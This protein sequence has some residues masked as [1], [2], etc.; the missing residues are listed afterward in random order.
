MAEGK[1]AQVV[2]FEW[3][4]GDVILDLYE[5]RTV[6]E[7]FGDNAREKDYHEGGFG[8]V[9]KVWHRTWRREMAVK[10]PRAGVFATQKQK[11]TFTRECETWINL[12]LHAHIAACHYVRDLCG[13]PRVFSEYAVAGTLED[14][15]RS[16]R[17]YEGD[18][19]TALARIL[20]AAI[21]FA[22]GLHY[23]HE[24]GVIHQDVKPL[25]ALMWDDGTLKVTDFGLTGARQKAGIT[26]QSGD[27][28]DGIRSIMVS[29]GGMT[30]SH[31]SPE[32]AAGRPLDRR[33][34]VWSWAVSV[35]EMFQGE[36]TW[37]SGS[38]AAEAL[39]A[40][41]EESASANQQSKIPAMPNG[42]AELLRQCFQQ[43]PA[44]R[45]HTMRDCTTV[46][47]EVYQAETGKSYPRAEPKDI[48]DTADALNNRAL[49]MLDLGKPDEAERLFDCALEVDKHHVA[50]TCNRSLMR[51]RAGKSTYMDALAS[52]EEIKKEHPNEANLEC[53]LGWVRME[54]A[55]FAK[56]LC[57]FDKA[58]ELGDD[59]EARLGL[60]QARPLAQIG[61]GQCLRTFEEHTDR[62]NCVAFSP[63]GLFVLSGSNDDTL[64]LWDVSTGECLRTFSCIDFLT[65]VAYSPD[66]RLVISGSRLHMLRLWDVTTGKCLRTFEG[67]TADV[68]SVA[69]S[70]DGRFVLSGSYDNTLRWW[71][72][73]TGQCIRIFEGHTA[74]V[75]SVAYSPDGRFVLSG[76]SDATLRLWDVSSVMARRYV[77]PWFYSMV[78]T[79]KE[80]LERQFLHETNLSH[81]REALKA[82]QISE[83]LAFL[84]QARAVPGFEKSSESLELQARVGARC[85]IKSYSGGW[86]KRTFEGQA[87]VGTRRRIR[88][89]G[90]GC[91][92]RTFEGYTGVASVAYSPDGRFVLSGSNDDTLRLWDVATGQCLRTFE[93]HTDWVESIAY[94]P[95]GRFVLSGSADDTLR[96]WD[97]AAGKCLRTFE[98]L[99]GHTFGRYT[100]HRNSGAFSPDG[101]FVLSGAGDIIN[102]NKGALRL[103]DVAT[104]K[105]LRTFEGHTAGVASVAY[106]PDGRFVLSGSSGSAYR[107]LRLWDVGTGQCLRTFEGHKCMVNSVVYSPDGRF[108]LSGSYDNTLRLWDVATGQCIR[109]FEGHTAGVA[110]VA[111]SPDGRFVLSG[112]YDNT[113][114]LWDVATG[115]CIRTFEGHTNHVVS[116][117]FSPD[118]RFAL[119]GS[120]DNMLK[121]WELDWEYEYAPEHDPAF[122]QQAAE[123]PSNIETVR[124]D[125]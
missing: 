35:L 112:S 106:S 81:A 109:T 55:D 31:C 58:I 51:W 70:P 49:S 32:Q 60:E 42:V 20:D 66:G 73:T 56:A 101:R 113:L 65:S 41:I 39:E 71:D 118:G 93:G 125:N 92:K 94:S 114:G 16:K 34:D 88:D 12:G 50:A 95:D 84:R 64:R 77:A 27:P 74:D 6:T 10:S 87:R 108:V 110:S 26:V 96:L 78:I 7:G 111:Y 90:S 29:T 79:A 120:K 9:Y 25:N 91:L 75:T 76:S 40:Y 37:K 122:K 98:G 72:V 119:S 63:D 24:R 11:D 33:T 1:T 115:K 86:L 104:G 5:V 99:D 121:L 48:G 105:C 52:L 59:S 67:H 53:A 23:A 54:M 124:S 117:A 22:W 123:K 21:Q 89:S 83:A 43:N 19:Q 82:G 44:D 107:T 69:Y 4:P 15:I 97:V 8:R 13:A 61:A 100:Y 14:W 38:A 2:A 36:V 57:H 47:G 80:A 68:T 102:M 18:K 28:G 116:V 17:I 85:R 103:W 46:L 62:I 3:K 45:P 30:P